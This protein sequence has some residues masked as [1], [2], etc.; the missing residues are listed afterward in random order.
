MWNIFPVAATLLG[1]G[2][3]SKNEE[4]KQIRVNFY[5]FKNFKCKLFWH[6]GITTYPRSL[7]KHLFHLSTSLWMPDAKKTKSA[8]AQATDKQP[9]AP[10]YLRQIFRP[11]SI[12]FIGPKRWQSMGAKSGLY[13]GCGDTSNPRLSTVS[14]HLHSVTC[15]VC[16]RALSCKRITPHVSSL[17]CLFC[18][19]VLSHS[20]RL[21]YDATFTVPPCSWNSTKH[22]CHH[23][24]CWK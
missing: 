4:V 17:F 1:L 16:G 5:L 20:S 18:I 6:R 12:L 19:A 2:V 22:G 14:S 13:G 9:I 11:P 15:T 3:T 21:Q 24:S 10:P 7:I 8:A 23:F